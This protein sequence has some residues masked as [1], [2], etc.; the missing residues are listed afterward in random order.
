VSDEPEPLT[1][2]ERRVRAL[3]GEL[4]ADTSPRGPELTRAVVRT[5][6]WQR[7]VRRV[8]LA[9]GT[10]ASAVGAGAGATIRAYRRR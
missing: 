6:R 5:A 1:P 4:G 9:L 3:L 8:L 10:A 2:A 7:P